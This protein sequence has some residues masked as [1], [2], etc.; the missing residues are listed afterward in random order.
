MKQEKQLLESVDQL[1]E[2]YSK[3]VTTPEVKQ[4]LVKCMYHTVQVLGQGYSKAYD[5][6]RKS[7]GLLDHYLTFQEQH[8]SITQP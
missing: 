7:E 1:A 6:M 8:R 5:R 3:D 2:M 4:Q